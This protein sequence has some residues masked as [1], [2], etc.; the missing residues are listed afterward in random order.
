MSKKKS[1]TRTPRK[2]GKPV[3]K[4]ERQDIVAVLGKLKLAEAAIANAER[5]GVVKISGNVL[6]GIR[7]A[8]KRAEEAMPLGG[9]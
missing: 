7:A 5:I 8:R 3:I 2:P 9:K 4:P 6:S 1:E